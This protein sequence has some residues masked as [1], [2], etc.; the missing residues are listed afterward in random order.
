MDVPSADVDPNPEGRAHHPLYAVYMYS[1]TVLGLAALVNALYRLSHMHIGYQW[2]ILAAITGLSSFYCVTIPAVNSKISI[3]DSLVFTNM[4][5]FG[6]PAGVLTQAMDSLCAS[7]RARTRSRRLHYVIFNV[8]ATALAAYI[9]G[10][11]FFHMMRHGPLAQAP[12]RTT[13]ELFVPLGILAFTHYFANS[14]SVAIIVALEK[15][16]NLFSVWRD[17]FLWTSITYF[18]G[19]ATAGFIA[20]NVGRIEPEMLFII[21]VVL[22]VVYFTYRTYLDKVAELQRLRMNLEGEVKQRTRALEEATERAISLA[23]AAEAAS[24]AKSDF[25]ATMSHEIR[26]PLNAVIGYS[27]M[28]EEEAVDL[29]YPQLVPDLQKITSAG[30]QLLSLINDILDFSK[31][32]AGVLKLNIIEFD[33]HKTVEDLLQVYTGSAHGKGLHLACSIDDLVPR[34][35]LGDPDR[36]RQ[37]L[38]N[39]IGNAIKFTQEGEVTVQVAIDRVDEPIYVRFDVKDTGIGVPI[40]A[41]SRIFQAFLHADGSTTRKYGGTGLGLAIV[42]RLV[43]MMNGEVGLQS[44]P[45]KGSNFW[46]T[47]P[48]QR[49]QDQSVV[50]P[51][52]IRFE[53]GPVLIVDDSGSNRELLSRQLASW[54]IETVC[55]AE[56]SRA[57]ELAHNFAEMGRPFKLALLDM[58]MPGTNGFELAKMFQRDVLISSTRLILLN[59]G[60]PIDKT[61]VQA[62]GFH[63]CLTKPVAKVQLN[64]C[65]AEVLE[66]KEPA[67]STTSTENQTHNPVMCNPA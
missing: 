54:G 11:V 33:L 47:V 3:G 23:D 6:I 1:V 43:E 50:L 38:T 4:V 55:A 49:V 13:G 29:G 51:E 53:D 34:S 59:S 9:S 62:G 19:A 7:C 35:V 21:A 52:Y 57:L 20:I 65:I 42:K 25:L 32:E 8:A 58:H 64:R 5:L 12:P 30:R 31:I 28:L 61:A 45:G 60:D 56:G 18:L 27:E 41:Q 10:S 22:F 66:A 39:L 24:R 63:A 36:L 48:F 67:A 44:E 2:L 40:E 37:I 46:F 15:R 17:S 26:T 16:K 14:G